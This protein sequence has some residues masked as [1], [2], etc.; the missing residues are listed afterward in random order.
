MCRKSQINCCAKLGTGC[1][2]TAI[3][4]KKLLC[5]IVLQ[6][7]LEAANKHKVVEMTVCQ[8]GR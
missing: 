2:S 6:S 3:A 1:A 8:G 4:V 5:F 7:I